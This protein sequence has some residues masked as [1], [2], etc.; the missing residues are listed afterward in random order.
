M[1]ETLHTSDTFRRQTA[2]TTKL[3]TP[4]LPEMLVSAT[5][6]S[7]VPGYVCG[8]VV[9]PVVRVDGSFYR[10]RSGSGG[11]AANS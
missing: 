3:S 9:A 11:S 6:V 10:E 7:G 5:L 2:A 1:C 8:S 4:H